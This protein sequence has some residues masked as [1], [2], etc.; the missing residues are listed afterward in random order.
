MGTLTTRIL[1]NKRERFIAT[2]LMA[3]AVPCSA[4]IAVIAALMARVAWYYS[5]AYFA[6]LIGIFVVVGTLLQRLTPGQSTE[7]LIDLPSLRLPRLDNVVRKSML[8]VW[9]FMKEVAGFFLV[10]AL[11]ISGCRRWASSTGSREP[12]ARSPW[13]GSGCRRRRRRRS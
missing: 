10:G 6:I 3:I 9:H 1:G 4:Q 5:L 7:L 13:A 8:K 12:R 2:A 11:L